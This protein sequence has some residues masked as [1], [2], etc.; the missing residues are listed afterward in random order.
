MYMACSLFV[1]WHPVLLPLRGDGAQGVRQDATAK[2][3]QLPQ[4][5]LLPRPELFPEGLGLALQPV[6]PM[7]PR[8]LA[9]GARGG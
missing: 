2:I 9:T 1:A 8:G 5:T 4:M 7:S 6:W 3:T